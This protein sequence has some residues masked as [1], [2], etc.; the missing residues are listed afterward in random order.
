MEQE[1]LE[2]DD[3]GSWVYTPRHTTPHFLPRHRGQRFSDPSSSSQVVSQRSADLDEYGTSIR[4]NRSSTHTSRSS[5]PTGRVGT[6]EQSVLNPPRSRRVATQGRADLDE[7][8]SLTRDNR[9]SAYTPRSNAPQGPL[10]R[11]RQHVSDPSSSTSVTAQGSIDLDAYGSPIRNIRSWIDTLEPNTAQGLLEITGH[12]VR[13]PS[14]T[15][16]METSRIESQTPPPPATAPPGPRALTQSTGSPVEPPPPINMSQQAE[17][18]SVLLELFSRLVPHDVR[19]IDD[20][21]RDL[22]ATAARDILRLQTGIQLVSGQ[23]DG[24]PSEQVGT[25][26]DA[27]CAICYEEIADIVFRPCNHLAICDVSTRVLGCSIG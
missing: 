4:H 2:L 23:G 17:D 19:D 16:L 11:T 8:E 20:E 15:T 27:A 21:Q 14:S 3:H 25:T 18:I 24:A 22:I 1:Q 10:E 7:Y 26:I 6:T 5:T 12:R 13:H 9:S